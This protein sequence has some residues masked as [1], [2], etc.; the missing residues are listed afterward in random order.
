MFQIDS[1]EI[2]GIYGIPPAKPEPM[3]EEEQIKALRGAAGD[4]E[5]T[6]DDLPCDE[7]KADVR[8]AADLLRGVAQEIE[9]VRNAR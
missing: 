1:D 5:Q 6:I 9:D 4:S 3:S 7:H 2:A 8:K